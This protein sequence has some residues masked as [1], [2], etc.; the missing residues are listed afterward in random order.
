MLSKFNFSDVYSTIYSITSDGD[1]RT[2]INYSNE[3]FYKDEF[4][5]T[6][7]INFDN[8]VRRKW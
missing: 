1:Y 5:F 8:I 2:Y 4:D 3:E 7:I 6:S